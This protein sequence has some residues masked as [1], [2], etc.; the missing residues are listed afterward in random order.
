VPWGAAAAAWKGM[1]IGIGGEHSREAGAGA[2]A[3]GEG[4]RREMVKP[5]RGGIILIS[6]RLAALVLAAGV[7]GW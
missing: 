6:S 2:G 3:G 5:W 4:R 1:E 7:G